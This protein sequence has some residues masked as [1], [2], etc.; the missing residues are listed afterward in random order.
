MGK[1]DKIEVVSKHAK[2]LELQRIKVCAC[3]RGHVWGENTCMLPSM[4][5]L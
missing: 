1:F 4:P 2:R 5:R 3:E